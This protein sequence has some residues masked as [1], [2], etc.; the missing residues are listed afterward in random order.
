MGAIAKGIALLAVGLVVASIL[1]PIP[2]PLVAV[3]V[4]LAIVAGILSW[5]V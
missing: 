5:I 4:V 1:L 2:P 3:F